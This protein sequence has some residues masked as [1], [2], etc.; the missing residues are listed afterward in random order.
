L[1]QKLRRDMVDFLPNG[2]SKELVAALYGVATSN[3]PA[4]GAPE[5]FSRRE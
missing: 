5:D 2:L 4:R 1:V 3:H